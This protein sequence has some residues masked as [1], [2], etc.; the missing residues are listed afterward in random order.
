MSCMI[1][2]CRYA[3]HHSAADLVGNFIREAGAHPRRE[4]FVPEFVRSNQQPADPDHKEDEHRQ[5]AVLD[6]WGFGSTEVPDLLV[7]VTFRNAA[8]P[9]YAPNAAVQPGWTARHAELE[10]QERYPPRAGRRVHTLAIE[11]W[12]RV[13]AEG[14]AMLLSL[15]AAADQRDWRSGRAPFGRFQRWRQLLDATV[16]H[17]IARCIQASRHGLPGSP[18]RSG[19]RLQQPQQQQATPP[20]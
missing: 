12:G 14:E 11:G 9:R 4:V 20:A 8:A 6:V 19:R 16:Q 7:D 10:K 3:L 17:G 13:G 1:G 15:R 5:F 2:P 18:C